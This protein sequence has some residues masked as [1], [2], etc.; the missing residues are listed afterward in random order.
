MAQSGALFMLF[1]IIYVQNAQAKVIVGK[2]S[3]SQQ[4][5]A[6]KQD[7]NDA[8]RLNDTSVSDSNIPTLSPYC[9]GLRRCYSSFSEGFGG[10][11]HTMCTTR[12]Q[13]KICKNVIVEA[14]PTILSEC[15]D[16]EGMYMEGIS[17]YLCQDLTP[18]D[19]FTVY[20]YYTE[21]RFALPNA[22]PLKE[23]FSVAI[24]LKWARE[25]LAENILEATAMYG[26]SNWHPPGTEYSQAGSPVY[27]ILSSIACTEYSYGLMQTQ[28]IHKYCD[29]GGDVATF[30]RD[31]VLPLKTQ[32]INQFHGLMNWKASQ[33]IGDTDALEQVMS[34]SALP[35]FFEENI[36]RQ[37]GECHP[38]N[39]LVRG[40]GCLAT[41]HA[42]SKPF[43]DLHLLLPSLCKGLPALKSC[44]K[45]IQGACVGNLV[46]LID[47]IT[48]IHNLVCDISERADVNQLI[49]HWADEFRLS[50]SCQMSIRQ[51]AVYMKMLNI[52]SSAT[53][54]S[55]NIQNGVH[56]CMV[57]TSRCLMSSLKQTLTKQVNLK[58][59][60]SLW[61]MSSKLN[62]L[63]PV[64]NGEV[65]LGISNQLIPDHVNN[66]IGGL[67]EWATNLLTVF[68]VEGGFV[69]SDPSKL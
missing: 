3:D 43:T 27:K 48:D 69:Q 32:V 5:L 20:K 53:N 61:E 17:D 65:P 50:K 4:V 18:N 28:L 46:N 47:N 6:P 44:W 15:K 52:K 35:Q 33:C 39:V 40:T 26:G 10:T 49:E 55:D 60:P 38:N 19:G 62:S 68:L 14:R 63:T 12:D 36:Q 7:K 58:F 13:F 64:L 29:H 54:V 37:Y 67:L 16:V 2:G 41:L 1:L 11:Y 57:N 34:L 9:V 23:D 22:I 59:L 45:P 66:I 51:S 56:Q 21:C 30:Y 8:A 25:R 42:T 31:I 24:Y